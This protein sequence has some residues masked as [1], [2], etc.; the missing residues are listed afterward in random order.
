MDCGERRTDIQAGLERAALLAAGGLQTTDS[1]WL[2]LRMASHPEW[3]IAAM[4]VFDFLRFCLPSCSPQTLS[5]NMYLLELAPVSPSLSSPAGAT[6][7]SSRQL[8]HKA[9]WGLEF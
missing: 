7:W 8:G 5:G 4:L 2:D 6:E 1:H 9:G 3:P